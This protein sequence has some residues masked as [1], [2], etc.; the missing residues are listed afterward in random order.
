MGYEFKLNKNVIL[1]ILFLFLFGIVIQLSR[2]NYL[3]RLNI[4]TADMGNKSIK[5]TSALSAAEA[6]NFKQDQILVVY[7][8]GDE[9]SKNLEDNISKTL[10]YMQKVH[11]KVTTAEMPND[12]KDYKSVIIAFG[13]LE[14]VNDI[15]ALI[16]YAANGGSLFLAMRP[17]LTNTFFSIYRKLGIYELGNELENAIGIKMDSDLLL[18]ANNL[19]ID[20]KFIYNSSLLVHLDE[21]CRLQASSFKGIPLLWSK[22]Y[23]K[24]TI[25]VQNGTM[26]A[27]KLNRGL[28]AGALSYLNE[29]FIY[30]IMNSKVVYIDDFPAPFPEGYNKEIY[31][32]YK[33]N[34]ASFF[35]DVWWPD[36]QQ[37]AKKNDVKYTGVLVETYNNRVSGPFKD[38]IGKENLKIFGRDL[39]KSGGEI[40]VHGYNH[41]SLT[42][43]QKQV[44]DLGYKAWGSEQDMVESLKEAKEYF[45]SIFPSYTLRTYVPPSNVLSEE[46]KKAIKKAIPSIDIFAS[47]Y[48][49][50]EEK[51]SY[52]QEYEVNKQFIELPRLTSDY[53][54]TDVNKWT[55]ANSATMFGSF[56]H[57]IHPD[58]LLDPDR[59]KGDHWGELYKQFSQMM[60]DVKSNYPWMKAQTASES[61]DAMKNYEGSKVYINQTQDKINVYINSFAGE[62]DFLLRSDKTIKSTKGCKVEKVSNDRYLV[63]ANANKLEIQL[64]VK[65]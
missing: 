43:D 35:R 28:I 33:R 39:L 55:I 22:S 16:D 51:N 20:G 40:G 23:G 14:E 8:P 4:G 54:Y 41:Q 31:N 49:P 24:G 25:M 47:L 57:F 9:A 50:D 36:I 5:K 45:D 60:S 12:L 53:H 56:S 10:K 26:L 17:E 13:S 59:N 48:I 3:L 38:Q 62:L 30:P 11:K 21:T 42:M 34:T 18:K 37:T 2:S 46:G 63:H 44:K 27:D 32:D 6:K 65:K 7:D 52:I 19:K 61:A 15:D 1:I 64:E 58:D 29:D